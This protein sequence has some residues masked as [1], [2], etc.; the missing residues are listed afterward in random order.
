MASSRAGCTTVWFNSG[1]SDFAGWLE[2][3]LRL[4][5]VYSLPCCCSCIAL[6]TKTQL[7]NKSGL[8]WLTKYNLAT[9]LLK[10]WLKSSTFRGQPCICHPPM[11]LV[12]D[13][14]GANV[15]SWSRPVLRWLVTPHMTTKNN[16]K[17]TATSSTKGLFNMDNQ[18]HVLVTLFANRHDVF[19]ALH[20]SKIHNTVE[21]SSP[22]RSD[23]V[24]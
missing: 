7:K 11:W 8:I 14:I 4:C 10:R 22:F 23:R 5:K 18:L 9:S 16:K 13:A 12:R 2:V 20:A 3:I 24:L 6:C 15:K 17:T 21:H 1:L 19:L